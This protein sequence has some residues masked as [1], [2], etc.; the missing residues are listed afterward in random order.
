MN[1]MIDE[2]AKAA[3]NALLDRGFGKP[4]QA[5][6]AHIQTMLAK[7]LV[8]LSLDESLTCRRNDRC[9]CDACGGYIILIGH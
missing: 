2:S 9:G 7:R 5:F 3:A 1:G 8:D 6:D 4:P